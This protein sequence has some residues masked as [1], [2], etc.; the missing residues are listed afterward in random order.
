MCNTKIP[1]YKG[2]DK[3]STQSVRAD[4]ITKALA[5]KH[6]DDVFMT[7]VRTGPGSWHKGELRVFDAIGIK[8]SWAHPLY[9]GYEV[10]VSRS[11]FKKDEKWPL[12]LDFC[13]EF[14][15]VCPKDLIK[16]DELPEEVGLIYFN[17]KSNQLR[18]VRKAVYRQI[19]IPRSMLEY[20]IM[21]KVESDRHPFF[22]TDRE[23]LSAWVEDRSD[24][25]TLGLEVSEKLRNIM[26]KLHHDQYELERKKN[27][28]EF[29]EKLFGDLRNELSQ[30]GI[31]LEHWKWKEELRRLL[32][33]RMLLSVDDQFSRISGDL[34]RLR[35][36]VL[37]K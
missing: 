36:L 31:F 30:Y 25:V 14:S 2:G 37:N 26:H 16:P 19:E 3:V 5:E 27:D 32:A 33:D 20:I 7:Q 21:A 29:D 12:Y 11:D 15:F 23:L 13:H 28:V 35:S 24:R 18:T 10:K 22:S 9:H 17:V 34:D 4:L 1:Y 6:K 8:R